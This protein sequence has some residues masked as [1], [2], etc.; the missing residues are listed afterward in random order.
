MIFVWFRPTRYSLD[1]ITST[2]WRAREQID[3]AEN[4]L[5][6]FLRITNVFGRAL[7]RLNHLQL[8]AK[9]LGQSWVRG[10][11]KAELLYR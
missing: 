6:E 8:H 2:R 3:P 4:G 5:E 7:V 11:R 9:A 1:C 10:L